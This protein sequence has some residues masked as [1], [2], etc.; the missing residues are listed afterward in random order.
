[1]RVA[2]LIDPPQALMR[3][4]ML[5]RVLRHALRRPAAGQP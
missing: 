2:G 4:P 1:M 3:P 5:G